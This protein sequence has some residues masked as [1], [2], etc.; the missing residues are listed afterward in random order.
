MSKYT[1]RIP[2][3]TYIDVKASSEQEAHDKLEQICVSNGTTVSKWFGR[4]VML[5]NVKVELYDDLSNAEIVN[6]EKS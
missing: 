3:A 1:F 2:T 4:L 5:S 6:E